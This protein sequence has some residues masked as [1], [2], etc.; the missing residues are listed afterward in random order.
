MH[1]QFIK[2]NSIFQII[3]SKYNKYDRAGA[4]EYKKEREEEEKSNGGATTESFNDYEYKR[5]IRDKMI[6]KYNYIL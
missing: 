1:K 5:W 6:K 2:A 4:E 3:N